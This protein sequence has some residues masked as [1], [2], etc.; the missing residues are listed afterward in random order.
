VLNFT[1]SLITTSHLYFAFFCYLPPFTC[2]GVV[3]SRSF[4]LRKN[5]ADC[6]AIFVVFRAQAEWLVYRTWWRSSSRV[7]PES[8]ET[9][10]ERLWSFSGTAL[11]SLSARK[12]LL[13]NSRLPRVFASRQIFCH[14][15]HL[16]P[17]NSVKQATLQKEPKDRWMFNCI[18]VSFCHTLAIFCPWIQ[19]NPEILKG[20][21]KSMEDNV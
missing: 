17:G 7:R 15:F 12:R 5:S 9:C 8:R 1:R 19:W 10:F 14:L 13:A 11:G 20:G 21:G 4:F 2:H 18:L 16:L 3:L 6:T